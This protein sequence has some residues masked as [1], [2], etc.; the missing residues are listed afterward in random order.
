MPRHP[1]LSFIPKP[2]KSGAVI[3]AKPI[4]ATIR[5]YKNP[6]SVISTFIG[7]ASP[8]YAAQVPW[9]WPV[10]I[11]VGILIEI[12]SCYLF[13]KGMKDAGKETMVPK[14]EHTLYQGIYKK[15]RHPQALGEVMLWWVLAFFLNSPLLGI[16]L[17]HFNQPVWHPMGLMMGIVFGFGKPRNPILIVSGPILFF[18]QIR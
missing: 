8:T 10:S 16:T 9:G 6:D 15:I 14:K 5:I 13:Y 1:F 3:P 7:S 17:A 12:P 2:I 11:G 18:F 4:I